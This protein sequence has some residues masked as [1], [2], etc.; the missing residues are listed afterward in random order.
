MRRRP[1]CPLRTQRRRTRNRCLQTEAEAFQPADGGPACPYNYGKFVDEEKAAKFENDPI[2]LGR[3][4][5]KVKP[6]DE[7]MYRTRDPRLVSKTVI[8]RDYGCKIPIDLADTDKIAKAVLNHYPDQYVAFL[9]E[10]VS[11]LFGSSMRKFLEV[12]QAGLQRLIDNADDLNRT[13]WGTYVS[14]QGGGDNNGGAGESAHCDVTLPFTRQLGEALGKVSESGRPLSGSVS[15]EGVYNI[16]ECLHQ[17][18]NTLKMMRSEMC[19]GF[20]SKEH[21][22]LAMLYWINEQGRNMTQDLDLC[23]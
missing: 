14:V 4:I 16:K 1:R 8:V 5:E 18:I 7:T 11:N 10:F 6:Y 15:C 2:A 12:Q 19:R 3:E 21:H 13:S 9:G 22:V 17:H 23:V 20:G